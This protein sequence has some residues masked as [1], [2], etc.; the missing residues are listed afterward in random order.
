[1]HAWSSSVSCVGSRRCGGL[2]GGL[3]HRC[4][5]QLRGLCSGQQ[6]FLSFLLH[7]RDGQ[8]AVSHLSPQFVARVIRPVLR[9]LQG[10]VLQTPLRL[11]P[12]V[13]Q[14]KR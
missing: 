5:L 4:K 1:M 14:C 9:R 8:V 10:S 6:Q 3:R 11:D 12:A 13:Q 7:S 2:I